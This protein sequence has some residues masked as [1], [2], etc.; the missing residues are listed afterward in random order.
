[1]FRTQVDVVQMQCEATE[2]QKMS[3]GHSAQDSCRTGCSTGSTGSGFGSTAATAEHTGEKKQKERQHSSESMFT[4]Y[5]AFFPLTASLFLFVV[6]CS[7]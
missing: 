6:D 2:N 5:A 3:L 1:M 4:C 7:D